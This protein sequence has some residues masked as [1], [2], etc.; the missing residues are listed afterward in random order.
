MPRI[1]SNSTLTLKIGTPAVDYKGDLTSYLLDPQDADGDV[2]T[3]GDV[4]NGSPAEWHI[5]GTATQDTT[6]ASFWDMV[7]TKSGQTVAFI[8]APFGNATP[9]A[10][11]PHFS[12]S[13]VIGR[14]P[15]V[16]GEAGAGT[17][18][19]FTFD[20]DWVLTAE[21]TKLIA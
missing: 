9:T 15:P 21:P 8:L 4:A 2:V 10:A 1:K 5:T 13:L 20:F 7:W 12:G 6:A 11:Q 17:P 16:G 19:T 14:K 3:F 18:T